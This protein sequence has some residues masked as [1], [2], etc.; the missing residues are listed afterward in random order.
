MMG[1]YQTSK[2]AHSARGITLN[3]LK[4][5]LYSLN[6]RMLLAMQNHDEDAQKEVEKQMEAVRAEMDLLMTGKRIMDNGKRRQ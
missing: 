3:D 1:S 5:Q 4:E 6:M 2:A